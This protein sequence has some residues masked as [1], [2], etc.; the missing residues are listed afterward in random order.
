MQRSIRFAFALGLFCI[1]LAA[2]AATTDQIAAT[3]DTTLTTAYTPPPAGQLRAAA[4]DAP[5]VPIRQF[6]FD[7]D[8]N[9][10]FGS[11]QNP[12]AKDHF[13][14]VFDRPVAVKSI[15]VTT[16]KPDGSDTLEA[17]SLQVSPDGTTFYDLIKFAGGA[18]SAKP[19]A[20]T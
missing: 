9:T 14:L 6:A 13:T 8:P 10:Y 3:V 12:T 11:S 4:A 1:P 15:T 7:G 17:A 16:G 18:A 19:A 5:P 2:R 20:Q